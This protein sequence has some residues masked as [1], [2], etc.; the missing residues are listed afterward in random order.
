MAYVQLTN[1][2]PIIDADAS[3]TG[4]ISAADAV[5]GAPAGAGALLSGASTAGSYVSVACPGGDTSWVIQLTGTF[6]GTTVYFEESIDSTNGV[7]GNWTNVNGRQTGVLNTVLAAS[8]T[9]AGFYRGNTAGAAYVRA[10]AVGGAAITITVKIKISAGPGAVFL[11]ASIPAGTNNIGD[12]DILTIAAGS[13]VIG[14]VGIDQTTPGTTNKVSLGSDVVSVSEVKKATYRA[15]TTAVLVPAVTSPNPW[16]V[17]EGSASKTIRIQSI[18]VS[19]IT[20]TAVA[21]VNIGLRK[22]ST[23]ASGGTS[24]TLTNVPLDSTQAAGTATV[25]AYTAIPTAG[26]TVGDIS[27]RRV[28]GQATTAAAAGIPQIVDFDFSPTG[29]TTSVVL[30]GTAQGIGLYF[31][32]APATTIS[33]LVRIEWTEE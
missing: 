14:K 33:C 32:T 5:V 10:R 13:N 19:G 17:I 23:A 20:L 26:T 1:P 9:A 8:A 7:D 4:T 25:K 11:N 18:I 16:F 24:T 28:I 12:V 21:Y 29:D 6:G 3:G 30:R 31:I 2:M 15:S 22:Y 27:S